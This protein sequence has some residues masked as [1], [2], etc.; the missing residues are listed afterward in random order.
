MIA[1]IACMPVLIFYS[2][3]VSADLK[4]INSVGE[5]S[6]IDSV[7]DLAISSQGTVYVL[8][9]AAKKVHKISSAGK[10]LVSWSETNGFSLAINKQGQVYIRNAL[11][12]RKLTKDG[13][14]IKKIAINSG[15]VDSLY[16]KDLAID[17]SNRVYIN[18]GRVIYVYDQDLQ[19][20]KVV[21]A[22]SSTTS[23]NFGLIQSLVFNDKNKLFVKTNAAILQLDEDNKLVS[24][25]TLNKIPVKQS[26]S[27]YNLAFD[28]NSTAYISDPSCHCIK[29]FDW[30]GNITKTLGSLGS[31]PGKFFMPT[32]LAFDSNNQLVIGDAGNFR[33]QKIALTGNVLW[34]AGDEPNKFKNPKSLAL[35][36]AGNMYVLDQGHARVQKY[37]T[38]GSWRASWG[39]RGYQAGQ[40]A[41]LE[42]MTINPMNDKVYIQDSYPINDKTVQ[43][44]QAFNTDGVFLGAY[45]PALPSFDVKGNSYQLFLKEKTPP[46]DNSY[47][48]DYT[49]ALQKNDVNSDLVKEWLLKGGYAICQGIACFYKFGPVTN[50][51]VTDSKGNI[52]YLN[53]YNHSYYGSV[54]TLNS[55][56]R[57]IS[58]SDNYFYKSNY[59]LFIDKRDFIY[60]GSVSVDDYSGSKVIVYD[61][62]FEVVGTIY[63]NTDRSYP[64]AAT[65]GQFNELYVLTNKALEIYSPASSLKAPTLISVKVIDA[66]GTVKLTW[67]DQT[68]DESGF[69][70]KVCSGQGVICADKD[71][72]TV[73]TTGA[74]VTSVLVPSL[75]AKGSG[76]I[77]TFRMTSFKG[78]EESLVSNEVELVF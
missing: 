56:T 30:Q 23:V 5:A 26:A 75:A 76:V 21:S 46:E 68:S 22:Y 63:L 4:L 55:A 20:I 7:T 3:S 9:G 31:E 27:S 52:Y 14:L 50:S 51:V 78:T 10:S 70:I 44:I 69:K 58:V 11:G 64:I 73:K 2:S 17:S 45:E 37:S 38:D 6:L 62:T 18:I 34:T 13:K 42:K 65:T 59:F 40:L 74:N 57:S 19:F 72:V 41:N 35:D 66:K 24:R 33:L 77:K 54:L 36:S 39:I 48:Y 16:A 43:R 53:D 12:L 67:K 60:F 8:D 25:L 15:F 71:V 29:Q 1:I 28:T 49:Y 47:Y 61:E 32:V